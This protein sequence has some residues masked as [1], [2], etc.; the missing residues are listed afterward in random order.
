MKNIIKKIG[1]IHSK[2]FGTVSKKA[3]T[4]QWWAI[5]L[6][7]LVVYELIEHIVYP[8]LVPYLIYLNFWSK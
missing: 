1:M 6:T 2:V 7:L 3:E 8:I 4:S 5:L